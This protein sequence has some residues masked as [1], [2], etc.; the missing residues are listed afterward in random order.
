MN[1]IECGETP[2]KSLLESLEALKPS[3][4]RL[5]ASLDQVSADIKFAEQFLSKSGLRYEFIYFRRRSFVVNHCE[6]YGN[7]SEGY[8]LAW[9]KGDDEKFR[10]RDV[11]ATFRHGKEDVGDLNPF[12]GIPDWLNI[13]SKTPVIETKSDDR[14]LCWHDLREFLQAAKHSIDMHLNTSYS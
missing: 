10:L 13:I 6:T 14:V 8:F 5:Q 1:T 9:M 2:S 7:T 3:I 11:R 12:D 4:E